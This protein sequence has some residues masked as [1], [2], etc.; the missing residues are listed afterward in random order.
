MIL[1]PTSSCAGNFEFS[2]GR[3]LFANDV[4]KKIALLMFY[5]GWATDAFAFLHGSSLKKPSLVRYV[6]AWN[7]NLKSLK[8]NSSRRL[9]VLTIERL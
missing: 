5:D 6:M 3:Y 1:F 4:I 7:V 8:F 2:F 9:T